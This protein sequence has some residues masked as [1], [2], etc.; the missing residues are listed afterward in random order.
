MVR[1]TKEETLETYASLLDAA[2]QVFSQKGVT[3][4][5]L[6]DV[7]I[8]AGMTRG[9]IYW[10]FKDK[11]ALLQAMCDRAFL[12]MEALLNEILETPDKDPIVALK[13]L[14]IHFLQIVSGDQRQ[15]RVF[16]I[17]FHRCEKIPTCPSL[18]TKNAS[19]SNV[20]QRFRPSSKVQWIRANCIQIPI[21]GLLCKP[22]TRFW[23]ASSMYGWRIP[24]PTA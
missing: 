1:K 3:N 14:D 21:H 16:D 11:N 18:K 19:A 9:A 8:A 12:P 5:T 4:T 15:R 7:A 22:T 23:L 17:I 10:H 2:E 13:Q 6:N 20:W 24:R